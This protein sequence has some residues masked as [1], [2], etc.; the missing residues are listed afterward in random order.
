MLALYHAGPST[1]SQKVRLVLAEKGLDW[2]DKALNF[3]RRDHLSDWYLALNPN[4]V[5]PTLVHDGA[6]ITDS[7]VIAE[8]LDDIHPEPALRPADPVGRAHLR[9]WRQFIDE[10]PTTAIRYPSFNAF[11]L[12]IWAHLSDEEFLAYVD[13]M[14]LR[15]KLYRRIKDRSGFGKED[16]DVALDD[17]RMTLA[18]MDKAL[19]GNDWLVRNQFSLADTALTPTIVRMQ[20]L[21]LTWMWDAL[22]RVAGWYER[23]QSRPSFAKTYYPGTRELSP[24]C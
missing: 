23:V 2:E 9:A 19:T 4:G 15:K 5:V 14:P 18:R 13:G 10:V 1:C 12:R 6:V 24:A 16:I 22:P 3:Q 17:L 7:S 8:Y 20:D 21:G 11:V